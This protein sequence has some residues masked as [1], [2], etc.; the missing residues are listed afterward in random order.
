MAQR[1]GLALSNGPTLHLRTETDPVYATLYSW[2]FWRTDKA[3]KLNN[4]DSSPL[5]LV[6]WVRRE[7]RVGRFAKYDI[8]LSV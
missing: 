5:S 2:E 1:L 8:V 7:Q 4:P 3:Q 6:C